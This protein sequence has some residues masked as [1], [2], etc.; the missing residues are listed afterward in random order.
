M[1]KDKLIELIRL[2]ASGGDATA[3]VAGRYDDREIELI[4]DAIYN[5]LIFQLYEAE[6]Q[7]GSVS[8]EALDPFGTS[9]KVEVFEDAD[10]KEL[11]SELPFQLVPLPSN[12]G[13]RLVSPYDDQSAAYDLVDNNSAHV[14]SRLYNQLVR[15][16]TSCYVE[17]PRIYYRNLPKENKP[18]YIMVK[19]IS[20]FV[21]LPED[22]EILVPG[23]NQIII[24]KAAEYM[25]SKAPKT[26]Y[27]NLSDKQV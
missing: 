16:V 13:I 1:R 9:F 14:F 8:M 15:P 12:V 2:N 21:S 22:A 5:D 27:D 11:Y 26:L 6:M 3:P 17:M 10:R 24:A 19:A 7:K 20:D 25:R 18:K 4:V 23:G